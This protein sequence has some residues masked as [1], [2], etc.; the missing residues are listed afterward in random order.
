MIAR[1]IRLPRAVLGLLVG[2]SLAAAGAIMQGVTRN[3]L[4]GPSIMGLSAGASLA[5]LVALIAVPA[6]TYNGSIMASLIGALFGYGAVLG[7]ALLSPHG[8]SPARLALAG[9]I[10]SSLLGA[11][12]HALIIHYRLAGDMLYWTVGGIATASWGQVVA[13][14]PFCLVGLIGA[15][16]VAPSITIL[17]LG[18][19]MAVGLGQRLLLVRV[20]STVSVLLLT[21]SAVAVAGP[22]GFVGLMVPHVCR[23]FVGADFRR[24]LP[25]SF[26][27]GA[28][29]TEFA[30]VA[31]RSLL[32]T[33]KEIPLG[34]L[35]AAIGA[36]CFIWIVQQRLANRLDAGLMLQSSA[37]RT[38]RSWKIVLPILGLLMLAALWL[39]I[40]SGYTWMS[41]T[42]VINTLLGHG[43]PAEELVLYSFRL[44]RAVFT[45]LAGAGIA[46]SGAMFQC[47]LRNDLA[48]PGILGV[49][50]GA[51]LAI[52][53]VL[54][55][56]TKAVMS[57]VFFLPASAVCGAMAAMFFVYL[58]CLR[59]PHS[60]IRLLLTGVAVSAAL[61]A[62][63]M[64]LT[65][66]L[67]E[68]LYKFAVAFT[69]GSLS[70]AGW[71]YVAVLGAWLAVLL[72]LAW[73]HAPTLNV[74]RTGDDAATGLG[75]A[76]V[77]RSFFL[78][79]LAVAIS[80]ACMALS[81]GV[82]FLGL[83]APHIARR[84]IGPNQTIVLPASALVGATLLLIADVAGNSVFP[85]EM[86]A[87]VV[88]SMFGA[89]YFLYLLTR[90]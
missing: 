34:T 80:A 85:T 86:P 44:P 27:V 14:V 77:R 82:M 53:V 47:I 61:S 71:N 31:A 43:D 38:P 41:P 39:R 68:R 5:M 56:M 10:V 6:L 20:V 79:A 49:S 69:A 29:L 64:L 42:T 62:F 36:P 13:V 7:V 48:E 45:I 40:Q 83:I 73:S 88:V 32:E 81:G 24:L 70:T 74:L 78:L 25:M 16:A 23:L 30:D 2:G 3:P 76:V 58:L 66:Q 87:G 26:V 65:L 15:G 72:P 19:E 9:T 18:E 28:C 1:D 84:L 35:T 51:N 4:A 22:I 11:L 33:W 57:D 90:P 12:T 75:V 37:M 54:S 52:I 17:S 50:A 21:G 46:V 59:P 55:T 63:T 67:S 89:P 8:F 60:S